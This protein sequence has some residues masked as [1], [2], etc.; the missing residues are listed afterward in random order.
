MK[1]KIQLR[2]YLKA[3]LYYY[4]KYELVPLRVGVHQHQEDLKPTDNPLNMIQCN[5]LESHQNMIKE[6]CHETG[7]A[8]DL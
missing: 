4:H 3:L 1:Y 2:K 6:N 7:L 8:A 5:N